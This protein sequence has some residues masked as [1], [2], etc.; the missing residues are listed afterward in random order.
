[1][2]SYPEKAPDRQAPCRL[3]GGGAVTIPMPGSGRATALL[4]CLADCGVLCPH[5]T[6]QTVTE[7]QAIVIPL[8]QV[9]GLTGG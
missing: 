7:T 8:N 4:Q 1:M 2:Q 3:V 9:Y 6:F 5:G